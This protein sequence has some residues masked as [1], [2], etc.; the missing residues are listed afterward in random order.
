MKSMYEGM[1]PVS[2]LSS[3]APQ[4]RSRA[5]FGIRSVTLKLLLVVLLMISLGMEALLFYAVSSTTVTYSLEKLGVRRLKSNLYHGESRFAKLPTTCVELVYAQ[6]NLVYIPLTL[7]ALQ[8]SAP[9]NIQSIPGE[10]SVVFGIIALMPELSILRENQVYTL[11]ISTVLQASESFEVPVGLLRLNGSTV[12]PNR[13]ETALWL[14]KR[15]VNLL[16]CSKLIIPLSAENVSA[17]LLNNCLESKDVEEKIFS[18]FMS[19]FELDS[20][21][22]KA[23]DF[24]Y[25]FLTNSLIPI[26]DIL[27]KYAKYKKQRLSGSVL[28]IIAMALVVCHVVVSICS[29]DLNWAKDIAIAEFLGLTTTAIKSSN[30]VQLHV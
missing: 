26:D 7:C 14:A 8:S 30:H 23:K 16:S 18:L 17:Y 9:V 27:S 6:E 3:A 24:H 1:F 10:I 5:N 4:T 22:Y 21:T 19:T 28:W 11:Q 29:E 2:L 20:R 12:F 13:S 25:I 15:S